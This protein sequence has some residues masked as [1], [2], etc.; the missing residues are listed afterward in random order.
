MQI[1]KNILLSM[2]ISVA[3]IMIFVGCSSTQPKPKNMSNNEYKMQASLYV[4]YNKKNKIFEKKIYNNLSGY[5]AR[6]NDYNPI[7]FPFINSRKKITEGWN[8]IFW[9]RPDLGIPFYDYS[10]KAPITDT[11]LSIIIFPTL[12]GGGLCPVYYANFN[13]DNFDSTIK[14]FVVDNN[15]DR[16]A[17][18][19]GYTTLLDRQS[20][21][22]NTLISLNS[23]V[24]DKLLTLEK[25]YQEQYN[26]KE[27]K[28]IVINEDLS[29]FYHNEP[30]VQLV[31]LSHKNIATKKVDFTKS[32]ES[33]KN[34]AFPCSPNSQCLQNISHATDEIKQDL[35]KSVAEIKLKEKAIVKEYNSSLEKRTKFLN[36]NADYSEHSV[37][38][39]NKTLYYKL[40]NVRSEVS[41]KAKTFRVT[42]Q[43][44]AASFTD[45]YPGYTNEDKNIKVYFNPKKETIR[46]LNKTDKFLEIGSISIY[47]NNKIYTLN[48]DIQSNFTNELSPHATKELSISWLDIAEADYN[49][50]TLRKIKRNSLLFGVAVK[51][52]T[53]N[54]SIKHTLYR[55]DRHNLVKILEKIGEK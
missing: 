52:T 40:K 43:I 32:Y 48:N 41:A 35:S 28:I 42:Y 11:I 45:I 39:G 37:K 50:I 21:A 12:L 31:S 1:N 14:E 25:H 24:N 13:R 53:L 8:G 19:D 27:P 6:L 3:T 23:K 15:I 55:L 33:I 34:S 10:C 22:Q 17:L 54:P 20:T 4:K 44:T 18:I 47:Y 9:N 16:K 49:R 7:G 38:V 26:E 46:L 2:S 30:L 51:Y 5:G 29:G 36:V